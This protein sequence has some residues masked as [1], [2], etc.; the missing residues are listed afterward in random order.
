M[1]LGNYIEDAILAFRNVDYIASLLRM[2]ST[3]KLVEHA[4]TKAY[5]QGSPTIA[6]PGGGSGAGSNVRLDLMATPD[7]LSKMVSDRRASRRMVSDIPDFIRSREQS[8]IMYPT[9]VVD[10]AGDPYVGMLCYYDVA[11]CRMGE[12]RR[13]RQYNLVA[14]CNG[15]KKSEIEDSMKKYVENVCPFSAPIE[16]KNMLNYSYHLRNGCSHTKT[17]PVRIY[18]VACG[19]H[20]F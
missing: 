17:K 3:R 19:S 9:R 4:R 6:R 11:F 14:Y 1:D 15:V 12:S 18:A 13:E 5:R 8:L 7:L 2:P 10:H 16:Q 20:S